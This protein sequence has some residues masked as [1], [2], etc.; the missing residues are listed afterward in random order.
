M[1]ELKDFGIFLIM[2]SLKGMESTLCGYKSEEKC[3]D[4]LFKLLL[5]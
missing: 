2:E 1:S 3:L 4:H 5:L